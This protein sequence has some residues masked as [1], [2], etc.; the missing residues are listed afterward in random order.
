LRQIFASFGFGQGQNDP[1]LVGNWRLVSVSSIDNQSPWESAWSRAQAVSEE[2]SLLEFRPDGSWFRTDE[3]HMIVGAGDV[4]LEDND[5]ATSQGSWNAGEGVLFMV[6][7]DNSYEEY[8]YRL[9]GAQLRLVCEGKGEVW[10][11]AY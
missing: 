7:D 2:N 10:E 6:W 9:Q 1:A 3:N 5:R 4:W 8:E 11:R